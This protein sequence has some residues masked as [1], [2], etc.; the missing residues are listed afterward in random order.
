MAKVI[1]G[2]S[3]GV[4][5]AV[6][7]LLLK[8]QGHEVIGVTLRTWEAEDGEESRCCEIDDAR[9]VAMKIGIDFHT[10]NCVEQFKNQV[11]EPF[12]EAY[13]KGMTPNPCT[14]CNRCLKWERLIHVM[15][16][17]EADYVATG[18]YANI[19]KLGNGRYSA[20]KAAFADKDQTYMLYRLSQEQLSHTLMPLGDISK[21]EVREIAR[22]AGLSVAEK[23]DSQE[24]CFVMNGSYT[25]FIEDNYKGEL[26]GSGNFVDSEGK[27]LGQHK[28]IIHYT[29]G[30]RKGLGISSTQ[31]LYV[32][33]IDAEKNEVV[34]GS[35]ELLYTDRVEVCD[36]RFTAIEDLPEGEELKCKVKIRYRHDAK[37]ASITKSDNGNII[38]KFE[39]KV[40]S[41]TPGQSAVF[42]DEND[43][44][45]GGG[46]IV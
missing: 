24:I 13:A 25:D 36:A 3:G 30:Q 5:S 40:K 9:A 26:K 20:K 35:E 6:A 7:A 14:E 42:Y 31:P 15:K 8:E 16:V 22:K 46:I 45:L 32:N 18:H 43:V 17:F 10:Y 11:V 23:K 4:D 37:P 1:V 34:L 2:M 29:I 38:I 27:V 41:A 39:D 12:M 21:D 33:K 44:L 28:G 19:V